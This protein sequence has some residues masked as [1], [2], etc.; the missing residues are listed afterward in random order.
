MHRLG[1]GAEEGVLQN[2]GA[3]AGADRQE[4]R[5]PARDLRALRSSLLGLEHG[6]GDAHMQR[7][8]EREGVVPSLGSAMAS[9]AA[10]SPALVPPAGGAVGGADEE[11]EDEEEA[12]DDEE[13]GAFEVAASLPG[14]RFDSAAGHTANPP[15]QELVKR[16]RKEWK[17]LRCGLPK[18]I[19]VR[20]SEERMDLMRAV[21]LGPAKTPYADG[22]FVFDIFLPPEYPNVAPQVLFIS[23]G[24][25]LNPNLY[26]NGKVCLSLL[27]TWGG[28]SVETWNASTS[29]ILQVLVSIQGLVLVS[30][31][32]YNEAGYE[33]QMGTLEGRHNSKQYNESTLLLVLKHM[34]YSLTHPTPPL[35]G[36]IRD[37]FRRRAPAIIR[38]CQRILEK[39]SSLAAPAA[40]AGVTCSSSPGTCS[41]SPAAAGAG[42][43]EGRGASAS[44]AGAGDTHASQE[45]MEE[46]DGG[47]AAGDAVGWAD[48]SVPESASKGFLRSLEK[49][50]PRLKAV[51][52]A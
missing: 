32:Y 31:P 20:A 33:K 4:Q 14:H 12:D 50:L 30:E 26:D 46:G 38:R 24:D 23:Y 40:C 16:V 5:D 27:G 49:L 11:D 34:I 2:A 8:A 6:R 36:L 25:R 21:I 10:H 35:E 43:G 47:D 3:D 37:H 15:S 1:M 7:V 42:S 22:F 41:S 45:R 19:Y 9:P 29:T 44:A 13:E 17:S 39:T 48:R 52:P 18:G 51:L 28:D